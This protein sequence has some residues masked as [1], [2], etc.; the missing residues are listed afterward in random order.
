MPPVQLS[1]RTVCDRIVVFDGPRD[2]TG[3]I[4]LVEIVQT[5]AFTLFG[6]EMGRMDDEP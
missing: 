6:R 1:G 5:G 4:V 3:Q 2:L